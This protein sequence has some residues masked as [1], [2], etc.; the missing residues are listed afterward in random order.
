MLF[1]CKP[2]TPVGCNAPAYILAVNC[3]KNAGEHCFPVFFAYRQLA[4]S[5]IFFIYTAYMAYNGVGGYSPDLG[6]WGVVAR[7]TVVKA[8]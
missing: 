7:I 4:N 2:A 3:N 8:I 6:G 5:V 1:R